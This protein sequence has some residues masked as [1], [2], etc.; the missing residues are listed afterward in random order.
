MR[1]LAVFLFF[2][3]VSV[4]SLAGIMPRVTDGPRRD[5]RQGGATIVAVLS[6]TFWDEEFPDHQEQENAGEEDSR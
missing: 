2:E 4:A 1:V 5:F 3:H 6:K